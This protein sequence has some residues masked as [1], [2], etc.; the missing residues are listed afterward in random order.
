[1]SSRKAK[2]QQRTSTAKLYDEDLAEDGDEEHSTEE[3]IGP[4][5]LKNVELCK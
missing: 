5:A 3:P 1:M 2:R 4:D